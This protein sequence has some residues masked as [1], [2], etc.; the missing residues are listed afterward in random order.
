MIDLH[1]H[2]LPGIDDGTKTL[3][4]AIKMANTAVD[5]GIHHSLCTPH[6]NSQY[7]ASVEKIIHLVADLKKELD[8]RE[9]P[10][11][12]YEGQEIRIDG[13][14]MNKI[15]NNN[16]LFVDLSN[17]YLLIE[18]PTREVPAYA[19]QLFFE[20]L[21]KGHIPIIVHP[22]RNSMLIENPNRLIPFLKMGV[23]TQ[24]TAPSYVGIFGKK[25]AQ[26][27]K[28]MLSHN[29]IYMVAS[30]AHC[31]EDR[32]FYLASAYEQIEK[33]LG[34]NKVKIL[35]QTAKDILNGDFIQMLKF[36]KISN[37]KFKLF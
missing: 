8:I 25:I 16:L 9:I 5:Q 12:L 26:T 23:L 34:E 13:T 36:E 31:I 30:D 19:E 18:F 24:M 29:M 1:C 27:A 2:I 3:G 7:Y 14:I 15:E 17:R 37:R 10:L 28:Q 22:E 33:D 32:S 35:K 11:T 20:L 21:N 4:D 6:H